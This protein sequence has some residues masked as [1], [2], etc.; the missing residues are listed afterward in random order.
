VLRFYIH[1]SLLLHIVVAMRSFFY[2]L[3][4]FGIT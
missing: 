2:Q 3:D 1:K 4:H